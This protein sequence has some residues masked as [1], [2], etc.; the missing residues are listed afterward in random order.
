MTLKPHVIYNPAAGKGRAGKILPRVQALLREHGFSGELT[1]TERPGHALELSRWLAEAGCPLV[2]AAGGD[3]TVNEVINGL[4][5]APTGDRGRATL[6]VIPVGRGNDFAFG[7]GIPLALEDACEVV[8]RG[9]PC[10]VDIGRVSG[11]A[12]PQGR[13]FGNGIGLG[14]DAVVNLEASKMTRLK[15]ILSYLAALWKTIWIYYKAPVYE[16]RYDDRREQ[17]PFLMITTMIGRRLGGL[18]LVAPRGKNAD[19]MFDV[20]L[21]GQVS[22][23]GILGVVPLFIRGT[24]ERHPQVKMVQAKTLHVRAVQGSIPAHAD[25]EM[26]CT[27]GRELSIELQPAA[28][29]VMT[30]GSGGCA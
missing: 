13:Y 10:P 22:Q 1:L 23:L 12:V 27:A 25:G 20:C 15:G 7:A 21:A 4:M 2:V 28:L 14:F 11:D 9:M 24:Q 18:F 30:R 3:G 19:G 5:Q 6:G 26:I 29:A 8:A 17:R 16:V